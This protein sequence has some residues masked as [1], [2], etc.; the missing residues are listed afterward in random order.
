MTQRDIWRAFRDE[1]GGRCGCPT[2]RDTRCRLVPERE[3][4]VQERPQE[5]PADG[6]SGIVRSLIALT[7]PSWVNN[8]AHVLRAACGI[9][10]SFLFWLL[11]NKDIRQWIAG[12]T[13]AKLT[14]GELEQI[15][16][17]AGC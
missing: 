14:R 6:D 4:L 10:Q 1:N 2:V 17:L 12:G 9:D 8:H 3:C 16:V 13:R 5:R 11:R 15:E 7:G